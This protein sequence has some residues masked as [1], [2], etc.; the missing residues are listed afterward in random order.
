MGIWISGK[1]ETMGGEV[2]LRYLYHP[3]QGRV[4]RREQD[5][6]VTVPEDSGVDAVDVAAEA[7]ILKDVKEFIAVETV[8]ESSLD[9]SLTNSI[10]D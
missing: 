2:D 9:L 6:I 7:T 1:L 8:S 3:L 5:V 4:R 10:A